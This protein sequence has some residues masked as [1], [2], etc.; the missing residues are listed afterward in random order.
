[1]TVRHDEPPWNGPSS[2]GI[3]RRRFVGTCYIVA[4]LQSGGLSPARG[5]EASCTPGVMIP[6]RGDSAIARLR[7]QHLITVL[8]ICPVGNGTRLKDR[9]A[10]EV[11]S[12]TREFR[13]DGR[14]LGIK[15]LDSRKETA[16]KWP[17]PAEC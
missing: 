13:V 7:V 14:Q 8:M 17:A 5:R 6:K 1:M 11:V 12:G 16:E 10:F 3:G 2:A 15:R 9:T 4:I